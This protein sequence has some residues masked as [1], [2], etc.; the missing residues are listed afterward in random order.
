MKRLSGLLFFSLLCMGPV[1]TQTTEPEEPDLILPPMILEVEDPALEEVQ[2]AIPEAED[3]DL[4]LQVTDLPEP[5]EIELSQDAFDLVVPG[6]IEGPGIAGGRDFFSDSTLGI[7]TQN[8][9]LG[10]ISLFMLGDEPRAMLRFHHEG[11]DGFWGH[12][13]GEGY[14]TRRE[15]FEG[16]LSFHPGS[17]EIDLAGSLI[18]DEFGFQGRVEGFSS[19]IHRILTGSGN[20]EVPVKERIAAG[21]SV[22]TVISNIVLA[23]AAG[24][25]AAGLP[26]QDTEVDIQAGF[27]GNLDTQYVRFGLD[28]EYRFLNWL[29]TGSPV[30]VLSGSVRAE[31]NFPFALDVQADAGVNWIPGVDPAFPFSLSTTAY[32]GGIMTVYI[33]GGYRWDM[34]SFGDLWNRFPLVD[35]RNASGD[36]YVQQYESGW[37][38]DGEIRYE[39]SDAFSVEAACSWLYASSRFQPKD[40]LPGRGLFSQEWSPGTVFSA[41]SGF[42]WRIGDSLTLDSGVGGI[43]FGADFINPSFEVNASIEYAPLEGLFGFSSE[44]DYTIYNEA[45]VPIAMLPQASISGF[46]RISEGVSLSLEAEDI[47]SAL[48][49]EPS[50]TW[51]GY[52]SPGFALV[53]KTNLSL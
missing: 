4:Y 47:V 15:S 9:F 45:L 3:I 21:G 52:T 29:E 26:E 35:S 37:F 34:A 48:T 50:Y 36:R 25:G 24:G 28:G 46:F 41:R 5:E 18:E 49:S 22:S 23:T 8:H 33:S 31:S 43:L 53:F 10:D 2:A 6:G 16:D 39:P 42:S 17:V 27:F 7:G 13:S 32:L 44:V 20:I 12:L 19:L 30:H 14:N 40:F 1:W 38:I 51:G 11:R